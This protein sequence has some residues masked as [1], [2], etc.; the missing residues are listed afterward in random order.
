MEFGFPEITDSFLRGQNI[1]YT[2]FNDVEFYVEDVKQE[3]FY[4]EI[5]K[6][7]FPDI[8]FEKIF[9]LGGKPNVFTDAA[10]NLGNKK[11]V[12]I[13][14]LDFDEILNIR[15]TATNIFY[16]EKYSIENYLLDFD[17]IKKIII[18]QRPKIKHHEIENTFDI[19]SFFVECHSLFSD[20]ICYYITI[21]KHELGIENVN[22]DAA[23]FCSFNTIPATL[24]IE[25]VNQYRQQIE[26]SLRIKSSKL[27]LNAQLKT[28]KKY[29]RNV[30]NSLNNIPGKYILNFLKYRIEHLFSLSQ[31]TLES[32]T[33]RLARNCEFKELAFLKQRVT[34]Y[35]E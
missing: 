25:Q 34:S 1:V 32:F 16:L 20:L 12:Y 15:N 13:V 21:Q 9:P 27:K 31:M 8:K 30:S 5:L 24:K 14:D 4:F 29:L 3:N 11:K 2:Q 23:R 19:N 33:Y 22:C 6:K 28:F 7:L 35:I 17:A 10:L 26:G 18:E